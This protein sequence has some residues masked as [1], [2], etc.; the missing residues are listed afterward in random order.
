MLNCILCENR[1]LPW[2]FNVITTTSIVRLK[3]TSTYSAFTKLSLS[4]AF[5]ESD[6]SRNYVVI[7]TTISLWAICVSLFGL[8]QPTLF[9]INSTLCSAVIACYFSFIPRHFFIFQ[10][11]LGCWMCAV[12]HMLIWNQLKKR[13]ICVCVYAS[14]WMHACFFKDGAIW[15]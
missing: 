1:H 12:L 5:N 2:Q 6:F 9:Q 3:L 14:F 10:M 13:C 15:G 8:C 11:M 4:S 7:V